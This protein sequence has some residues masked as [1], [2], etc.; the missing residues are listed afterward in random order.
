MRAK[1]GYKRDKS[2][3]P[4]IGNWLKRYVRTRTCRRW[5]RSDPVRER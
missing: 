4:R 3:S 1:P 5:K 2:D